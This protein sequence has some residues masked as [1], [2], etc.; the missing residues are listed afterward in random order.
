MEWFG[1]PMAEKKKK[2]KK[3]I[4]GFGPWGC[5]TTPKGHVGG[6]ATPHGGQ[7]GGSATPHLFIYLFCIFFIFLKFLII[8]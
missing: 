7:G 4:I 6:S 2:I 8:F 1:H 3:K 5:Q